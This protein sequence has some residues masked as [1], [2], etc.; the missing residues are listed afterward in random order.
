M[1]DVN[2]H[3]HRSVSGPTVSGRTFSDASFDRKF[4]DSIVST[5]DEA[6]GA[7]SLTAGTDSDRRH[8]DCPL[9]EEDEAEEDVGEVIDRLANASGLSSMKSPQQSFASGRSGN[10]GR[11]VQ[12]P[13]SQYFGNDTSMTV[14]RRRDFDLSPT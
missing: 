12:T 9:D 6:S 2:G 7:R 5:E 4:S 1:R 11:A 13:S 14:R 3:G 10:S 8:D